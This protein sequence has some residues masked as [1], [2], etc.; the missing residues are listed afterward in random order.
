MIYFNNDKQT[1][2][3]ITM[4]ISQISFNHDLPIE[5][6][7]AEHVSP[8]SRGFKVVPSDIQ[9]SFRCFP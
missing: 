1:I 3:M 5:L 7:T 4:L 2:K 8:L 9:V 6:P